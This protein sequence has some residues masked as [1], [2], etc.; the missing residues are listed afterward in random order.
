ML[1]KRGIVLTIILLFGALIAWRYHEGIQNA[2]AHPLDFLVTIKQISGL[3]LPTLDL[4][5]KGIAIVT[6]SLFLEAL[7]LGWSHS[8]L[9]RLFQWRNLSARND[10]FYW[11]LGTLNVSKLIT[12]ILSFGSF[13]LFTILIQQY[14]SINLG[15]FIG[16]DVVFY[17]IVFVLADLNFYVWHYC[18][19]R[20]SQ[21]WTVHRFHHSAT[22]F[23]MITAQ[24]MHF[25]STGFLSVSSSLLLA[26]TGTPTA[27]YP[28]LYLLKETW[29]IWLHSNVQVSLG[30]VGRYIIAT[31]QWHKVHHSVDKKH[32]DTNFGFLFVFWDRL[33]GTYRAPEPIEKIGIENNPYNKHGVFY[34]FWHVI[35]TF[36]LQLIR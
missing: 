35:K 7:L 26:L 21:L 15:H 24:R 17:L 29:G 2:I 28:I 4:I 6:G 12:L 5:W 10:L 8:S 25:L 16:N 3:K 1:R 13:Y 14:M 9:S 19:H 18:M 34:D 23:N 36:Y 22:E 30:W 31:P 27:V 11:L 32:H 20:I 33:F